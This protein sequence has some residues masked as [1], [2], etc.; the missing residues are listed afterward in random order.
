MT[1]A[2]ALTL[3]GLIAGSV[4]L[5]DLRTP[6]GSAGDDPPSV[7]VI[8][9][10]R[11]EA[12]SL[13]NLLASLR[14]Q[15][16]VPG[17]VL[18][19]DDGS[20]DATAPIAAAAGAE[21]LH[22][23]PLPAGWVGKSWACQAGSRH[24]RGDML[25]FLDAD[26]VLAP[27]GLERIVA[28]WQRESPDG[29]LSVQ[30]FHTTSAGYEQLSAYPNLLTMMAPGAFAAGRTSWSPVAYGPCLVTSVEA[31]RSVGGHE[32]VAGEVIE[33]IHLARAYGA[34]GREVRALAGGSAISFRMYPEGFG[35]LVEGWTKNLA[36]GPRLV[37]SVPMVASV[38]WVVAS[39]VVASDLARA[40][41]AAAW[42]GDV[43]G[44]PVALWVLASAQTTVLLRRIGRFAWW[45][46]PAFPV[47]L[48]GFVVLFA[49][50]ALHRTLGRTVRWHDRSVA[51]RVR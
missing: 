17:Q 29:L 13:P 45:A 27:D 32:V 18:V 4:L 22:A 49:R 43:P 46:G 21:V 50:S 16:L 44:L 51:V 14:T 5:A 47:L 30:P 34:A 9:P 35:R 6:H 10:A 11:N 1:V 19:V 48:A 12:H 15:S 8:I 7:A 41:V 20:T 33:D 26:T 2:L 23:P 3:L 24:A 28:S 31:Y 40:V 39:I 37:S 25:V 38:A 42:T 36:G